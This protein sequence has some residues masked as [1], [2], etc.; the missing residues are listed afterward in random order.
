M[1][2]TPKASFERQTGPTERELGFELRDAL[3]E[4]L[5]RSGSERGR[6]AVI[7]YAHPSGRTACV[8]PLRYVPVADIAIAEATEAAHRINS[9]ISASSLVKLALPIVW[10]AQLA[11]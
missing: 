7:R 3:L 6:T 8:T 11:E 1:A 10:E 9:V 5:P 4:S 2:R